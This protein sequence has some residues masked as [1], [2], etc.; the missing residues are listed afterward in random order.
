[1]WLL[2]GVLAVV[3]V[4]TDGRS[5]VNVGAWWA[6]TFLYAGSA[7]FGNQDPMVVL[8]ALAMVANLARRIERDVADL[9][10]AWSK[11]SDPVRSKA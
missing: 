6:L 11:R 5:P 9:H 2:V 1:M 10:R 7:V 8:I 4:L 3:V